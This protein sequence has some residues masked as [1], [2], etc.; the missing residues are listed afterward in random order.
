MYIKDAG[1]SAFGLTT[2]YWLIYLSLVHA[3]LVQFGISLCDNT[4][5]QLIFVISKLLSIFVLVDAD[6]AKPVATSQ[7]VD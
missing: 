4:H 3:V 7:L 1:H 2:R 6:N 5:L